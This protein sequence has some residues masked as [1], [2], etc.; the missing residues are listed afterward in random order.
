MID[1]DFSRGKTAI[2]IGSSVCVGSGATNDRGWSTLVAER[3]Q[4]NGWTTSNC[5]IGGQTTAD[6]LLRLERDVIAHKP[7][8]CFV[9]LGLANEGLHG[10]ENPAVPCGIFT[11]NLR[12]IVQ[13]L[14]KAGIVPIVG[15]VYPN[16]NYTPEEHAWLRRVHAELGMWENCLALQWLDGI[17]DAQGH[18]PEGWAHDAGHP[19]DAGYAAFYEN[20]PAALWTLLECAAA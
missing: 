9:G 8:V 20:I 11:S 17:S 1:R 6:I 7:A 4:R 13:A 12:K 19:N 2:F 5:S 15:G 18:F 16:D 3:M 10:A 14:E